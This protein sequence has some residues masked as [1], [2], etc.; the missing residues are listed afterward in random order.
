MVEEMI[1][2]QK[3]KPGSYEIHLR[4][5]TE[6][7]IP[8]LVKAIV[9]QVDDT[10]N[11]VMESI[12][13]IVDLTERVRYE[14][15]IE[16]MN[17]TLREMNFELENSNFQLQKLSVTD[18][19]TGV[20]NRRGFEQFLEKEWILAKQYRHSLAIIILD[21]DFF[22]KYNDLYGHQAGDQC[23]ARIAITIRASLKRTTDL[24]SRYGGEEFTVVLPAT[25]LDG[26]MRVAEDIRKNIE[27][28][29]IEHA[30]STVSQYVTVSL[31]VCFIETV[32]LLKHQ[33]QILAHADKALYKSKSKGKNQTTLYQ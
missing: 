21:I 16:R 4:K 25:D 10:Q 26:V 8:V 18:A 24:V 1:S 11:M 27:E 19:L 20:A 23:L 3:N 5:K 17:K 7:L 2:R 28:L 31:G 9:T 12:G 30:D 22:K 15:E 29:H 32:E 6:E 13:M 33:E 14:A